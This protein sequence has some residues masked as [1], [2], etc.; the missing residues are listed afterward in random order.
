MINYGRKSSGTTAL[1]FL[2]QNGHFN[3]IKYLISIEN[4]FN[5]KL[6]WFTKLTTNG[7]NP[8]LS[9]CNE[10]QT[11]IINYLLENIYKNKLNLFNI[12]D[13]SN[14]GTTPLLYFCLGGNISSISKIFELFGDNID[15][16]KCD[17]SGY[18]PFYVGMFYFIFL[19]IL[20]KHFLFFTHCCELFQ[21]KFLPFVSQ[22]VIKH[23]IYRFIYDYVL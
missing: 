14:D 11:E 23:V 19:L 1:N 18:S 3:C 16:N 5:I 4:N 9:A 20:T 2:C 10:N 13:C 17:D 6:D 21:N 12:N 15:V 7:F 22:F 8:L